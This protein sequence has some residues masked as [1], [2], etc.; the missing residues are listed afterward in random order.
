V[1]VDPYEPPMPSKV[2]LEQA[3]HFA[4]ALVKGTPQGGK[5]ALTIFRDKL[6]ELI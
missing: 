4:E 5:I 6:N 3:G 2:T 1:H